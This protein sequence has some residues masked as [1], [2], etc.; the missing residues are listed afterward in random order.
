MSRKK[1]R[2][3]LIFKYWINWRD[4]AQLIAVKSS[5]AL[6]FFWQLYDSYEQYFMWFL[7][8]V[9]VNVWIMC[10]FSGVESDLQQGHDSLRAGQCR[11]AGE[12][13]ERFIS[14]QE[15]AESAWRNEKETGRVRLQG[16]VC[17][18]ISHLRLHTPCVFS[19]LLSLFHVGLFDNFYF[20][21][22][23]SLVFPLFFF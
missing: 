5:L 2:K 6:M 7:T 22:I 4:K 15:S 3:N 17:L 12:T 21:I 9:L 19:F 11:P 8:L 10:V 16:T 23:L 14:Q 20:M 18:F 13:T 1:Q